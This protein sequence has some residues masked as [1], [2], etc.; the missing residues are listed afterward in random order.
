LFSWVSSF[1]L[2]CHAVVEVTLIFPLLL[3]VSR[4]GVGNQVATPVGGVERRL[5]HITTGMNTL[6]PVKEPVRP[7]CDALAEPDTV[8]S[9]LV[10]ADTM[11]AGLLA[12]A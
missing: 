2:A 7:A 3:V 1:S 8:L 10:S 6:L 12:G 9:A 5:E 4:I 11:A